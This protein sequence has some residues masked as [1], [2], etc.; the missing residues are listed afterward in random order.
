[1]STIRSE[2]IVSAVVIIVFFFA[3]WNDRLA[4]V[5]AQQII[6]LNLLQD[7]PDTCLFRGCMQTSR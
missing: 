1:M 5:F 2:V 6:L 7:N 3:S 4:A